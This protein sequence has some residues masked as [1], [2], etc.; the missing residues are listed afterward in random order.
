MTSGDLSALARHVPQ[1]KDESQDVV[2][3]LAAEA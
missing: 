3:E 1:L 2:P